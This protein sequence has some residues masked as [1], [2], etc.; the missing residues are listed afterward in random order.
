[1]PRLSTVF[2]WFL[3]TLCLVAPRDLRAAEKP[4]AA[5]Q[6]ADRRRHITGCRIGFDDHFKVG[7]WTPVWVDVANGTG[8][9][10]LTLELTTSD[11]DGVATTYFAHVDGSDGP[12]PAATDVHD[13]TVTVPLFIRVGRLNAPIQITLVA[14]EDTPYRDELET[15]ML[16]AYAQASPSDATSELILQIG[17]ASIGLHDALPDSAASQAS[18][19]RHVVEVDRVDCLPTEWYGYE[20]VDIM[21]FALSDVGFC[22]Q[23][24][25][26]VPRLAAIDRWVQ[27][28]GRLVFLAGRNASKLIGDDQPLNAFVPGKFDDVIRLPQTRPLENFIE[29][30]A[31]IGA[32]GPNLAIATPRLT[33]V[34]GHVEIYGRSNELPVVVRSAHGFGEICFVG[35]DLDQPPLAGWPGRNAFLHA[36]LEPYLW[37]P[38][39]TSLPQHLSSLGYSDI[40]GALRHQL[41]RAFVSVTTVSFPIVA[42]LIV[43]YLLLIGPLDYLLVQKLFGRPMLGWVT[44]PLIVLLTCGGAV[45][46]SHWS[47]GIHIHVNQAEVVDV[48]AASSSVRGTYLSTLYDPRAA[49]HDLKLA[50]R[51]PG[52]ET[53]QS[54]QS[55]LSWFGLAGSG[56]GGMHASGAALDVTRSG[57]SF[58]PQLDALKDV[59]ILSGSTKSFMSRWTASARAP[60]SAD[61]KLDDDGI[62][63]GTIK[64]D[65]NARLTDAYLLCGQ[66]AYRL[67]D[68]APG[69]HIKVSPELNAVHVKTLLTRRVLRSRSASAE[70]AAHNVFMIDQATPDELLTAMMF[71][72]AL[73]GRA[74]VGL[75]NR[76]LAFCDLTRL[77]DLGRAIL[78]ANGENP[79]SQLVDG[80]SGL[81]LAA[82]DDPSTVVYRVSFPTSHA[83]QTPNPEP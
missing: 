20:A 83:S 22:R 40:S 30:P 32:T 2:R 53:P 11:N 73:G 66:W 72:D 77:L 44:F 71:Y 38:D 49:R 78:V 10:Q 35:L 36:V 68:V 67:G 57:Y 58:A 51:L 5:R 34:S 8:H 48:D 59:P 74:F 81:P 41:G 69:Q 23:L 76:Y 42:A 80:D 55:L 24:A 9:A 50:H 19:S 64:N 21:V 45:G 7:F 62:L 63:S 15:V 28:G 54:A 79:G 56:L 1:M 3:L 39:Q 37:T 75:P 82:S 13:G 18:I 27:L 16:S 6:S 33:D 25:N 31:L 26:D 14:G 61:L 29:S 4:G 65:S 52:D 60:A 70:S 46:I 43:A 17:T 12:R 47:K